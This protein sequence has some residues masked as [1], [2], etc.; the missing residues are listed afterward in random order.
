MDKRILSEKSIV[1]SILRIAMLLL[2]TV[3][4]LFILVMIYSVIIG[5]FPPVRNNTILTFN[6]S[7][8]HSYGN[9]SHSVVK[10][11]TLLESI[12]NMYMGWKYGDDYFNTKYNQQNRHDKAK[13]TEKIAVVNP[14]TN[15]DKKLADFYKNTGFIGKI[16]NQEIENSTTWKERS[17]HVMNGSFNLAEPK[18][19]VIFRRNADFLVKN[20]LAIFE[21][22]K[23]RFKLSKQPFYEEPRY[24]LYA[25]KQVIGYHAYYEQLLEQKIPNLN[26]I[27]SVELAYGLNITYNVMTKNYQIYSHLLSIPAS[28]PKDEVGRQAALKLAKKTVQHSNNLP[29]SVIDTLSAD[30]WKEYIVRY[31]EMKS[32]Y[33]YY[34]QSVWHINFPWAL[35]SDSFVG[36]D[37]TYND[38]YLVDAYNGKVRGEYGILP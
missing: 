21:G 29:S 7:L 10:K 19:T 13:F 23:A 3:G 11:P 28:S 9:S 33:Y 27:W 30:I 6:P 18:D 14:L 37:I 8:M 35:Y 38:G 26:G 24:Y 31:P 12:K 22:E 4:S 17:F 20:I 16:D 36:Y 25:S 32:P 34:V 5:D 1:G 2:I 15:W